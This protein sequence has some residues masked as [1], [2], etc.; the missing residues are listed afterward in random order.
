MIRSLALLAALSSGAAVAAP[1]T[2]VVQPGA[3]QIG[4]TGAQAGAPFKGS[5]GQWSAQVR[6]DPADLAHSAANVTI[7]TASAKTGDKFQESSLAEAEWFDPAHFPRATFVTRSITAAGP[8]RYVADGVLTIKGK[9]LPVRLPF[10]LKTTGNTA[11][12]SGQTSIDR[13]AYGIGAKADGS[14]QW[15]TRQI[16]LSINLVA[17]RQ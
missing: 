17:Q 15:V 14:G 16:G 5:F 12:M 4:F 10:T 8:G 6:F 3:G 1:A 11:T 9:A 13:V 2:W 7:A